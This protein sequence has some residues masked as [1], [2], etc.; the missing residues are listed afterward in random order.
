MGLPRALLLPLLAAA[1]CG[2]GARGAP[3]LRPT[4]R[5]LDEP[6]LVARQSAFGVAEPVE[7]VN[8]YIEQNLEGV[9][10]AIT[11]DHEQIA[12]DLGLELRPTTVTI[13]GNPVL[14]TALMQ[15]N[16]E[17]GLDLPLKM[18]CW[19]DAGA[20]VT[21]AYNDPAYLARRY[22]ITDREP[23][24]DAMAGVLAEIATHAT[25]GGAPFA[26]SSPVLPPGLLRKASAH[27]VATTIDRCA[28]LIDASARVVEVLRVDHAAAAAG[29]GLELRPT[30]LLTFGE[31]ELGTLLM[32]ENQTAGIDLPLMLLASEDEAGAV[33]LTYNDLAVQLAG[34]HELDSAESLVVLLEMEAKLELLTDY[35]VSAADPPPAGAV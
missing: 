21:L 16:Q 31:P 13:F 34:R 26:L 29:V 35:C 2:S 15:S 1:L 10:V 9:S 19:E 25:S 30:T 28:E 8:L 22:A 27:S 3:L 33:T 24:F 18:L 4:R 5:P 11:L 14:G 12:A 7:R 32:Q 23:Q 20:Q 6:F 17:I